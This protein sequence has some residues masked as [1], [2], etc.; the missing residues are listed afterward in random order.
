MATEA[1]ADLELITAKEARRIV[2]V[3]TENTMYQR[4]RAGTFPKPVKIGKQSTRFV[5]AECKEFVRKLIAERD[6]KATERANKGG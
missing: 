3:L 6:A 2:G 4:I 5:K 1:D